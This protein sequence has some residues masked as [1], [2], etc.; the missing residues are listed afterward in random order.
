M[1]PTFLREG[2]ATTARL[3]RVRR[4]HQPADHQLRPAA[5]ELSPTLIDLDALAPD[6]QGLFQ[7]LDPLVRVSKRGLPATEQVLDNTRPLLR[8]L[9]PFLRELHADRRLPRPLQARDRRVLRRTTPPPRRAGSSGFNDPAQFLHY[10]R[11]ANPVNPEMMAGYPYRLGD[12]PL[13]PVHRAGRL[14]QAPDRGPP[15]G[16]RQLPLH[17]EPDAAAAGRRTSSCPSGVVDQ[18]DQFVFGGAENRGKAP[19]CDPQAPLGRIVGQSG[20]FP[21]LQPLPLSRLPKLTA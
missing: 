3:T 14:R 7:D 15:R 17:V 20:R 16:V 2:R 1:L 18:I 6:L 9:D 10:L 13:E 12:Q 19:P 8:R 21:R 4:R 11:A 5:R